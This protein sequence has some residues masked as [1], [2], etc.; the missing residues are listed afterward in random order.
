MPWGQFL[1]AIKDSLVHNSTIFA[2]VATF[3]G[4]VLL[5]NHGV[6]AVVAAGMLAFVGFCFGHS[7]RS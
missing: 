6:S 5:N 1:G 4:L 2:G 3:T 7:S